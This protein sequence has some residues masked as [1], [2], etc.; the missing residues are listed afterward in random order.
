MA[1]ATDETITYP[2]QAL[3]RSEVRGNAVTVGLLR[4]LHRANHL[5]HAILLNGPQGCGKRTLAVALAKMLLCHAPTV[6]GDSCGTCTSCQ[7]IAAGIHPDCL[8]LP[9]DRESPQLAVEIVRESLVMAATESA[10]MGKGRVFIL[11]MVER[12]RHEAANALLKILEEPPADTHI[13]M[14]SSSGD[15]LLPTIRSRSQRF[16]MQALVASDLEA[17]LLTQGMAAPEAAAWLHEPGASLRS[18]ASRDHQPPVAK[19]AELVGAGYEAYDIAGLFDQLVTDCESFSG[20]SP[21]ARQRHCLRWWLDN[22][23]EDQRRRMRQANPEDCMTAIAAFIQARAD[24]AVN[25]SPR[26][27]IEGIALHQ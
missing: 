1:H 27:V 24:L 5:S 19:L 14:T 12:L 18:V 11:P 22:A 2:V 23:I 25:I 16:R 20:G 13:I 17:V 21:T 7:E 10:L 8:L 26:L 9:D 4:R 6:D 15:G 3:P